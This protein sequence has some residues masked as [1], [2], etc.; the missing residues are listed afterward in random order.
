MTLAPQFTY[1]ARFDFGAASAVHAA[2]R[3]L[4]NE[5]FLD[6]FRRLSEVRI[7]AIAEAYMEGLSHTTMISGAQGPAGMLAA[8]P[9]FVQSVLRR[10]AKVQ[11]RYMEIWALALQANSDRF[12]GHAT[13]ASAEANGSGLEAGEHTTERRVSA[14]VIPFPDRRA[15]AAGSAVDGAQPATSAVRW[16]SRRSLLLRAARCVRPAMHPDGTHRDRASMALA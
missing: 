5:V 12:T 14:W 15:H 9:P 3:Q 16:A 13:K 11:Q 4:F 7:Q 1:P 6:T 8:W 10:E 2:N